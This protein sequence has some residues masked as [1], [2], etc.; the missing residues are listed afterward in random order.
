MLSMPKFTLVHVCQV[1]AFFYKFGLGG[2]QIFSS[3][4]KSKT[5]KGTP[6]PCMLVCWGEGWGGGGECNK[7]LKWSVICYTLLNL[8][9]L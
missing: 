2:S 4:H 3:P 9:V 8:I 5:L 1:T 6:C 7:I